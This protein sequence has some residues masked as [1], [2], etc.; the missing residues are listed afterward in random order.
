M[1]SHVCPGYD[2]VD[3]DP[4]TL[5]YGG[6]GLK[7]K[8]HLIGWAIAGSCAFITLLISFHL[9]YRH[10]RNY[11]KPSEQRHIM[12]IVLMI[13]IYAVISFLSFRFYKRSIYFETVRD[14]YEAFVIYSFFILLL[15]YLGD[16]DEMQRSKITGS[17]RRKLLSPLNCFY[18]NPMNENFLHYMKYGIIQY[19]AIKPLCT[20]AAVILEHH[21]LYC[22]TAYDFHFG[23]IY[24]TIINFFSASIA[25]YCLVLFYQTIN[26]E[27]QEHSP[28]LKFMCVKMVVF[29]CYWQ[30]IVISL[31]AALGVFKPEDNWT[32]TDVKIGISCTLICVEM[33]VFSALH[34]YSFSYRPYVI[35]GKT[36]PVFM[37]LI[38]GFNP[39]DMGRE[40]VWAI[41]D[42]VLLIQGKPLPVREG[43]L[44]FKLKRAH[45]TRL[46]KRNRFFKNRKQK[47]PDGQTPQGSQGALDTA[48]HDEQ[49][50][51]SL[52]QN[53]D[54]RTY[55]ATSNV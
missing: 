30:T 47:A 40:I 34:V 48:D 45:T 5:F 25:L 6:G 42:V 31:V 4:G 28:F 39:V 14:C 50:R 2:E 12:R 8:R 29:F 1:Y 35:P 54:G 21:D 46:L 38:D 52:L 32:L 37:S 36:T 49:A 43:K 23:M 19:V 11:N 24:I 41:Q 13:P 15:T 51:A 53:A 27:I 3:P 20:L 18:Y 22:E 33:V 26:L 9:I 10:A 44:N 55:Q 17:D 16:D 7:G